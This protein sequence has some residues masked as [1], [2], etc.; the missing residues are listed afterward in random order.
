MLVYGI[1]VCASLPLNAGRFSALFLSELLVVVLCESTSLVDNSLLSVC[2]LYNFYL[3]A[4]IILQVVKCNSLLFHSI[5][6]AYLNSLRIIHR[7]IK[8]KKF[9][10]ET[11]FWKIYPYR[12]IID[13]KKTAVVQRNTTPPR[14]QCFSLQKE[15]GYMPLPLTDG[16]CF[17]G[18]PQHQI[19]HNLASLDT[20]GRSFENFIRCS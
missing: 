5:A 12:N 16:R 1:L 17:T 10:I 19:M 15:G 6:T 20:G 9:K 8:R 4:V 7:S 2:W 3:F 13:L 18:R 11:F 14:W